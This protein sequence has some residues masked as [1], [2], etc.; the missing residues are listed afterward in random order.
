MDSAR[1]HLTVG[2]PHSEIH[3]S[4]PARGS[5]RLIAACYVLHRLSVPRHPR[6]ALMTLDR[7]LC[8]DKPGKRNAKLQRMCVSRRMAHALPQCCGTARDPAMLQIRKNLFTMTKSLAPPGQRLRLSIDG[9][10]SSTSQQTNSTAAIDRPTG[11]WSQSGSNRRPQACKASA[12]PT[13][14][15]PPIR[16]AA[17]AGE[18]RRHEGWRD[19]DEKKKGKLLFPLPS[20]LRAFVVNSLFTTASR[21]IRMVGP[22]GFEP[23]TPRLSSV[24]SNQLSYRPFWVSVRSRKGCEDGDGRLK[25][26]PRAAVSSNIRGFLERR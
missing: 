2:F 3:G 17:R 12:L 4:K 6:N 25:A 23:P 10:E 24:C 1:D 20:C 5:P 11:W 18:P 15:W 9:K 19:H 26:S 8:R 13:E 22:G 14:L 7:L 21:L 16:R